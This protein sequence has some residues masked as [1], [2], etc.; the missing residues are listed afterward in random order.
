ME[1][2]AK[3]T[4][5][6]KKIKLVIK[7]TFKDIAPTIWN[8]TCELRNREGITGMNAMHH[9]N[10]FLLIRSLDKTTCEKLGIP[11]EFCF[12]NLKDLAPVQLQE[13]IYNPPDKNTLVMKIR[14]RDRFGFQ[15][16]TPFEI[17]NNSTIHYLIFKT[18][19][20]DIDYF[21][22]QIDL[23]GDIYEGFINRE[24]NTMKDLGQFFTDRAL[25]NYLVELC[26][27]KVVDGVTETVYDGAAGTGGFITQAI[28][29][30]NK[31]NNHIDWEKNQHNIYGYDMSRNTY[32]LLRLNMY[33]TTGEIFDSINMQDTLKT[34]PVNDHGFDNILMNPPFGV[35]GLLYKD[36]NSKIRGMGINGTKGEILF[37]QHCMMNLA[38]NGRCVIVV[39]DGVLF[40][41]TK[42]YT[43]TRQ[44][45][46]TH[47]ELEKVI[48]V[49]KGEF[50]KNT[51]V[52]TAVLFFRKTGSPTKEVKFVQVNKLDDTI[53]EVPLMTIPFE[54]IV[55]N[56]FSLNMNIYK[57]ISFG[58][59]SN[60]E[61]VEIG[62]IITPFQAGRYVKDLDG[63]MY[64]YYNSNGITGHLDEFM[65]DGQYIVQATSGSMGTFYHNG[66]FSSTN[67]TSVFTT[68][69]RCLLKY[70][71]YFIKLK[72]NITTDVCNGSTIPNLDKLAFK[73]IKI[74]IPSIEFQKQIVAQIDNIFENE[75]NSSENLV[76][77][78]NKSI[79][80]IIQNTLTRKDLT[81][82]KMTTLCTIKR[83]NLCKPSV[84]ESDNIYPYYAGSKISGYNSTYEFSGESIMMNYRL[85]PG[86]KS[87]CMYIKEGQYNCS[88]FSWVL[89][90]KNNTDFKYIYYYLNNIINYD[91]LLVGSTILEINSTTLKAYKLYIPP[92]QVQNTIRTQLDKKEEIIKSLV[93]NIKNSKQQALDIIDILFD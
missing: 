15:K 11:A 76:R 40:N 21:L 4:A 20:I 69:E 16:T 57:E 59:C 92:E 37:L 1:P 66:K 12:E 17:K 54:K 42:M 81:E 25:I 18:K 2:S 24:G 43:E 75:I 68:N 93:M 91:D 51:G 26:D 48:K 34:E 74:P 53:S 23:I 44:Y 31:K 47:F 45:L 64:P 84:I 3:A 32:V 49:G 27:P 33:F 83:G 36:M 87:P 86:A 88:R 85:S 65:F 71:Y 61:L 89:K 55:E 5:S 7:K 39:P 90:T 70:L 63:T 13:K 35:K 78:L 9:I 41:A 29:Y 67:F 50:F 58:E 56:K 80:N 72:I 14:E 62:D 60:Y 30:L 22:K 82:H 38:D 6:C 8:M 19:E 77:H 73:K 10:L 52:K 46:M 79:Y 28:R